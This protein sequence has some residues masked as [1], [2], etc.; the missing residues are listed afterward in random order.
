MC[1]SVDT[2][3]TWVHLSSLLMRSNVVGP[4]PRRIARTRRL[5]SASTEGSTRAGSAAGPDGPTE[6]VRLANAS[7]ASPAP[8]ENNRL[9]STRPSTE[10]GNRPRVIAPRAMHAAPLPSST[11][12]GVATLV[13]LRVAR[14][15][16]SGAGAA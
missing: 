15:V 13:M 6:L 9:V 1:T 3:A 12:H 8:A 4:V 16:E 2:S 14:A 5:R 7:T 10:N 11:L